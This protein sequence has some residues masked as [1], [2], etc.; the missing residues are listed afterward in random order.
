MS[1]SKHYYFLHW[2]LA[3]Y[4]YLISLGWNFF[5]KF[6]LVIHLEG[7]RRQDI[8]EVANHPQYQ[9]RHDSLQLSFVVL[10]NCPWLE[11]AVKLFVSFRNCCDRTLLH[12][13]RDVVDYNLMLEVL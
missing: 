8:Q 10:L 3:V 9:P 4:Y 13:I 6:V 5:V 11:P 7:A 1:H 12:T 2:N